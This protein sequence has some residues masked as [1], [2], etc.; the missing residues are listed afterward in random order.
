M[1]EPFESG[2]KENLLGTEW[3]RDEFE[4]RP[5]LYYR[6]LFPGEWHSI[7]IGFD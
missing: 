5:L 7:H 2:L 1:I 4:H 6:S 3:Q